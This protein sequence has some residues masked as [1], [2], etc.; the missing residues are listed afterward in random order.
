MGKS[1]TYI[2]RINYVLSDYS[3]GL[4]SGIL[5]EAGCTEIRARTIREISL[6]NTNSVSFSE[7]KFKQESPEVVDSIDDQLFMLSISH[8]IRCAE[9]E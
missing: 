3:I 4:I 6:L 9:K 5:F 1:S 8:E 2:V 7:I